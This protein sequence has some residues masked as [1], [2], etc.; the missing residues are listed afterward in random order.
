MKH[1]SVLSILG[2][3]LIAVLLLIHPTLVTSQPSQSENQLN[4]VIQDVQKAERAGA[5]PEEIRKL[6]DQLNSVIY[7]E[8]QIQNLG[9]QD[10][11]RRSQLLSEINS[12]L[13]NVVLQANEIETSASHRTFTNHL[14][15]YSTG[16][17]AAISATVVSNYLLHLRRKGRAERALRM[18]IIPKQ[19]ISR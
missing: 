5:Q 11:D 9:P 2:A 18:R 10:A 7:L 3:L 14:I 4:N 8:S 6:I 16:A 17:I 19:S 13:T 15:A 1:L 12:T